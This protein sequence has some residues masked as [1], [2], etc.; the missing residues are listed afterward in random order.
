[1]NA[2]KLEVQNYLLTDVIPKPEAAQDTLEV[3]AIDAS[4]SG[5]FRDIPV[6]AIQQSP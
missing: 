1:M 6:G 4:D 3:G 5:R 2:A